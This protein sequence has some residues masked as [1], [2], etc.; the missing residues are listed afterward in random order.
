M[1]FSIG[2]EFILDPFSVSTLLCNSKIV[3]Q[4]YRRCIISVG[5]KETVVYLFE[6]DIVGFNGI[7]GMDWLYS[8]Y[9][10]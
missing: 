5:T 6:L 2:L 3:R 7:L 4:V 8:C 9:E 10:Y 1:H